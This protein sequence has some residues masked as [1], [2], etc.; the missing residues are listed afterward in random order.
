MVGGHDAA[1][2]FVW[3][4]DETLIIFQTLLDGRY[5][6]HFD[7]FKDSAKAVGLGR[8]WERL[9][10]EVCDDYF[11]YNQVEDYNYP[12]VISLQAYDD[13]AD[14]ADFTFGDNL[15]PPLHTSDLTKL[16]HVHRYATN[17]Y[18]QGLEKLLTPEQAEEWRDLY[19]ATDAFTD[20][21]LSAGRQKVAELQRV[22]EHDPTA[23]NFLV[24]S[25]TLI[26]SLVKCLLFKLDPFFHPSNIFSSR[27]VGKLQCCRWIRDRYTQQQKF[28][29]IG[30]G[31]D[32]R[33]AA[34]VLGWAFVNISMDPD[35]ADQLT[36]LSLKS[37]QDQMKAV[38][39]KDSTSSSSTTAN[40]PP[41]SPHH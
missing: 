4:L 21:W 20:G 31:P 2:V 26:P 19:E 37:V 8:R 5:V 17:R 11:F 41:P 40:G 38:Y 15:K 29:A 33:E 16:S 18:E 28:C 36:R 24:T 23:F 22:N 6:Q 34:R 14:I 35:A 39:N 3:D 30:D 25:G 1:A 9:I 32:E 7:G 27:E 12:N 10:L 13:G